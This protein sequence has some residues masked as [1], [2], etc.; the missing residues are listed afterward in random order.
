MIPFNKPYLTGKETI[1]INDVITSGKTSGGG[2]YTLACQRFFEDRYGFRKTFL[3]TSCTHALELA[4]MLLDIKAGDEVIMPS[5]TFVSSANAFVLRGA[6]IVFADCEK[7]S[8]NVDVELV[9]Q[10]I[11]PATKAILAIHYAGIPCEIVKLKQIADKHQLFLIEDAAQALDSFYDDKPAGSFGHLAAFS[12][13]DSK[14]ISCGE[15]GLL[16]VNDEGFV[17]RAEITME[18]GTNRSSFFRGEIDKYTWVDIGSSYTPSELNAAFLLAQLEGLEQIQE[19]RLAVWQHY[20]Q[21][22]K[23]AAID[24]IVI[25]PYLPSNVKHNAHTFYLVFPSL[26]TKQDYIDFM[27]ENGVRVH[28][29]YVPLHDSPFY[30]ERHGLRALPMADYFKNGLVRLPLHN[31]MITDE[32]N[33]VT[34][35][36]IQF[37]TTVK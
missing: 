35:L 3:T 1:Y 14:N 4:A 10:L 2:K 25:Y 18:K 11:T 8:P 29:H 28:T 31:N 20:D 32:I 26:K 7:N 36:T 12:F 5:Y 13:H 19:R 33:T 21:A 15:G 17:K 6:T 37:L 23:K 16:V 27:T 34:A 30:K 24:D 22:L 9:Q